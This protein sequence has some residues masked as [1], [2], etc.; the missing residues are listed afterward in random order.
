MI[1]GT[2]LYTFFKGELVGRDEFGNRYYRGKGKPM[3]H[4]EKRWVILKDR[5]AST[6]PSE[7]H[8]WLHHTVKDP[9]T[10][11]AAKAARWQKEHQ[12]N[13]TGTA[14]AFRPA[15]HEYKGGQRARATGDYESW[16]PLDG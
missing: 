3:L 11:E 16:S 9:L 14:A 6:V 2:L 10:E 7:W 4:R 15:G 1:T 5:E 12:P 13:L 8:A